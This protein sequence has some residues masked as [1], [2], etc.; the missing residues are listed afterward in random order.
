MRATWP[1]SMPRP[2]WRDRPSDPAGAHRRRHERVAPRRATREVVA[3]RAPGNAREGADANNSDPTPLPRR[4]LRRP[5]P[6][7]SSARG[8]SEPTRG[9]SRRPPLRLTKITGICFA[10]QYVA[11]ELLRQE[12]FT[13][14]RYVLCDRGFGLSKAIGRGEIDFGPNF[15]GSVVLPSGRRRADHRGAGVHTGCFELFGHERI[16]SITDLKGKRV[17]VQGLGSSAHMYLSVMAA[18][19]GLD[20]GKDIDWVDEPRPSR[21]SCSPREDR[22]V[23]RLSARA[24]GS[25]RPQDRPRDP[26]QRRRPPWSQYF[27]CMLAGNR[28]FVRKYPVATKRVLRAILKAADLCATEPERVARQ[29][30][31]GGFTDAIRLCA[32]DAERAALRQMARI[33]PRGHAPL[34]RAA[35]ARGRA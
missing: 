19:V 5:A 6:P 20:P 8:G 10:P 27:C 33:R 35:P 1:V 34:L 21:W 30:V 28:E 15:A 3:G 18:H 4:A 23:P 16:R 25:A 14:V 26:Q 2:A 24:A 11:E 31:D 17:G 22:R 29:L 7:G 12:G 32:A 9:R 13:D